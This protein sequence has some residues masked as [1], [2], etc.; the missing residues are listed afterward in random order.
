MEL[1]QIKLILSPRR[2]YL[3]FDSFEKMNATSLAGREHFNQHVNQQKNDE[4]YD[5]ASK[6]WVKLECRTF[7]DYHDKYAFRRNIYK[8]HTTD[9]AYF[10]GLPGL[11]WSLVMKHLP[12]GKAIEL[13]E[14][15]EHYIEFQNNIQ[16]DASKNNT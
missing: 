3:W 10:L 7:E 14:K 11:S 5:Y 2:T 13:L 4:D 6:A 9:P 12:K 8:M 15:P 1:N 16:G